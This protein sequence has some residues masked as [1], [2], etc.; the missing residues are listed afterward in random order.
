MMAFSS[1][2]ITLCVWGGSIVATDSSR[3]L[4]NY[5]IRN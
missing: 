1:D 2:L 3:D 5:V 4:E